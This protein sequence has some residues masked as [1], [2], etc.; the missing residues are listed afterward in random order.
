MSF[1]WGGLTDSRDQQPPA[2]A[3]RHRS[4]IEVIGYEKFDISSHDDGSVIVSTV[5]T[6]RFSGAIEG[7]GRRGPH[8]SAASRRHRHLDRHRAHRGNRR[9]ES[10]VVHPYRVRAQP[11][12]HEGARHVDRSARFRDSRT[13]RLAGTWKL[14]RHR[15]PRGALVCR[16]RIRV[17]VLRTGQRHLSTARNVSANSAGASMNPP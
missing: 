2:A 9:R 8:P 4:S 3:T 10:R 7:I 16:R 1:Q 17:L 13:D 12:R 5:L 14:H 15:R 6:E 11:Q